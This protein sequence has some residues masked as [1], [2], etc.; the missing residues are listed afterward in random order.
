MQFCK[1]CRLLQII[2]GIVLYCSVLY[3]LRIIN[4]PRLPRYLSLGGKHA[5]VRGV[6]AFFHFCGCCISLSQLSIQH[7]GHGHATFLHTLSL[8][9]PLPYSS[10]LFSIYIEG[11]LPLISSSL[12]LS[13]SLY[14]T[15]ASLPS[16]PACTFIYL[17]TQSL[18]NSDPNP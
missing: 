4:T 2:T 15:S 12:S 9:Y 8:Y 16:L 10:P 17:S 18:F 5:E 13:L 14:I 1:K 11:H 3:S 6:K 7:E